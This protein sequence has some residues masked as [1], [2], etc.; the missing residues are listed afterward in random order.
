MDE[1]SRGE[2]DYPQKAQMDGQW[3]SLGMWGGNSSWGVIRENGGEA[4]DFADGNGFLE[5]ELIGR[6]VGTNLALWIRS[7]TTSPRDLRISPPPFPEWANG[8]GLGI[9]TQECDPGLEAGTWIRG[10]QT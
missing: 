7:G 3:G 2:K 8:G 6:G 4:A 10:M 1:G 5:A 9:Y